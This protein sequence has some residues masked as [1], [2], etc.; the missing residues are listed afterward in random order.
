MYFDYVGYVRECLNIP[1]ASLISDIIGLIILIVIAFN[2]K[3]IFPGKRFLIIGLMILS[4]DTVYMNVGQLRYGGVY[5]LDEQETHVVR[6][7]GI[8]LQIKGTDT[9][10]FPIIECDYDKNAKWGDPTGYEFTINNIHCMAPVKGDLKVG[11]YVEVEYLPKSG[12][13]LYINRVETE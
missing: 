1:L 11:D 3:M 9:Y 7:K 8:I 13:I 4:M 2:K 10:S 12:Y 5:L 6:D